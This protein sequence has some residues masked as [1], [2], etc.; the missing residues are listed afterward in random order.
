MKIW[1]RCFLSKLQTLHCNSEKI[2]I[3]ASFNGM[4]KLSIVNCQLKKWK[5]SLKHIN[6][7]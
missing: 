5:H 6:I 1:N 3:F 7:W 4:D 2:S